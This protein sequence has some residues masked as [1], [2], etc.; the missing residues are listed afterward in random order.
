MLQKVIHKLFRHRHFW[1]QASFSEI[2]ELYASRMLRTFALHMAASFLSVYL[3]Q[4]GYSVTFIALFWVGFYAFKA[5]TSL[6]LAALVA[7]MGPKHGILISNILFIPSMI[8][9]ALVP[10]YGP[11]LLVLVALFQGSSS[12]LYSIAYGIDFSKIR[13]LEHGGKELAYMNVI[14]KVTTALSPL[15][16]GLLAFW[17]GPQ[18]VLIFAAVLFSVA[19]VPLLGSSEPMLVRQRLRLR[20]FPWRM[21]R[22]VVAAQAALG[23]DVFTSGTVWWLFTSISIIGIQA[24]NEVYATNGVLMSVILVAAIFASYMFGRVIDKRRGGDLLKIS[25]LFNSVTHFMRPFIGTPIAIAGLNIANET[26]TTGYSLAYTKGNFDNADLSGDRVVY[27]GVLEA[28]AN[29]GAAIGA[30]TLVALVALTSDV[31]GMEYLFFVTA[32]VVLLIITARFPLY[33]R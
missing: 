10:V 2:A 14:E 22:G 16:G 19:A 13:S 7:Y 24:S 31:R 15:I 9:F 5:L 28:I 29:F 8:A 26:A 3:Y 11:W 21:V 1:R 20:A 6:P 33:K 23:F 27:I 4:I 12:T 18:V 32:A 17:L 30:L 25:A